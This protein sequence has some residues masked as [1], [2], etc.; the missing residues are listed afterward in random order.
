M[1]RYQ[2]RM[3]FLTALLL[4]AAAATANGQAAPSRWPFVFALPDGRQ[5]TVFQP[6]LDNLTG[7]QLSARAAVTVQTPGQDQPVYGAV[8]LQSR[9]AT[10]RVARTVNILDVQV[11]QSNFA[12]VD[13]AVVQEVTGALPAALLSHRATLSLDQLLAMM[14]AVQQKNSQATNLQFTPPQ[15]VFRNHAAVKVQYDGAARLVNVPN[16]NILRVIN[17]PFFVA[18]DPDS[19]QYFLKGAG[20]WF[21]A[22]DPMGPFQYVTQVPPPVAQL[23]D[24]SG[25]TDPQQPVSDAVAQSLEIITATDPTELIWSDGQPQ[26]TP[27]SGTDL[28]YVAN[29]DSDWFVTISS[30]QQWVLLSGRWYFAPNQ[31]G[32]WTFVPPDQLPGDFAKIPSDSPKA[33]VLAFVAGTP[34]AQ[35][36]LQNTYLP[37]TA[38][39]DRQQFDQPPVQYDGD[40]DFQPIEGTNLSYAI[41]SPNSVILDNGTYYCCYNAVWYTSPQAVGPW[42]LCT[43]V[44]QEIYGIPPSCPIYPVTYAYVYGLTPSYVYCGYTPGYVGAYP[45]NG[46]VVYGTGYRYSCWAGNS[47]IPRPYTFGFSVRYDPSNGHW[48]FGFAL[49]TGGGGLWIGQS[50]QNQVI[51]GG[52]FGYGGYRPTFRPND[53][54]PQWLPPRNL[55]SPNRDLYQR[56]IYA[57]RSD[58]HVEVSDIAHDHDYQ[59]AVV[60]QGNHP[61]DLYADQQGH[62]YRHTDQGWQQRDQNTWKPA[63]QPKEQPQE[64]QPAE[65]PK[66]DNNH[67]GGSD[68]MQRLDRDRSSRSPAPSR[69]EP[70]QESPQQQPPGERTK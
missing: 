7:D 22:A 69:E 29:S 10:D 65:I 50:P 61:D 51:G 18:L 19:R 5:V 13:P 4:L 36:A 17:T 20:R 40:A 47:Y 52:W 45:C 70:R 55:S 28:L 48:G 27:I 12:G 63:E 57:R 26:M 3:T 43:Q 62:L 14:A 46:V 54:H 11:P 24:S 67:G 64:H 53:F 66:E 33:D 31:N 32:P 41:N 49:A 39:V 8:W 38:A 56:N 42:D 25:Y 68:D 59:P 58:V 35:I 60:G 37:Q 16:T 15:I 2:F 44:P 9:I 6:Q 30:Q 23:A 21:V 1:L 34:Q